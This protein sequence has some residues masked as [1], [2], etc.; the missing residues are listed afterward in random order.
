[1]APL[2]RRG[3]LIV[4][5][6]PP[7][8]TRPLIVRLRHWV[9]DVILGVPALR[10]LE[11]AGY[12]LVLIGKPWAQ[13]LLAGEGW[14]VLPLPASAA[15]RRQQLRALKSQLA[16]EDSGFAHR[17]NLLLLPFSFGSALEA[18][19][20]GLRA[21]G[22]RY[23]GRRWL[24]HRSLARVAGEHE[25]ES[26]WRLAAALTGSAEP[27]PRSIKLRV[28]D[29]A[30]TAASK[31]LGAAGL[32]GDYVMI[33]PFAGGTYSGQDK[34]WPEFP[35][36]AAAAAGAW[37]LPI[38][39]CPGPGE[40]DAAR[41]E[42]PAAIVLEDVPLDEYAALLERCRLMVSNDTG[43]GHL[44]AAVGTPLVSV[45]GPT[46]P[47]QWGAWGDDVHVARAAH[48]WP[49]VGDVIALSQASMRGKREAATA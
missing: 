8:V 35:A 25:L 12:R 39:L 26:Y 29:A 30:R 24:L 9:G 1:M 17:T 28:S 42:L 31:R 49:A 7:P 41:R 47:G 10:A 15:G 18:R 32:H 3:I 34:R 5:R 23:E 4:D 43:P 27:P 21:I 16:A 20:A 38:V 46:D 45:I 22:Y 36:F 44:A 48:G 13:A 40:A 2:A 33:C 19:I 14:A 37:P 11:A 6:P